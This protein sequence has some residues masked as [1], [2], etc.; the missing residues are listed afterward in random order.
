M[1]RAPRST[2]ASLGHSFH[3]H[4]KLHPVVARAT[5]MRTLSTKVSPSTG[6][7]YDFRRVTAPDWQINSQARN[8]NAMRHIVRHEHQPHRLSHPQSDLSR[9]KSETSCMDN[10]HRHLRHSISRTQQDHPCEYHR[11]VSN[12]LGRSC[13]GQAPHCS[14]FPR[15]GG[16]S[17]AAV[18]FNKDFLQLARRRMQPAPAASSLHSRPRRGELTRSQKPGRAPV[19]PR[20]PHGEREI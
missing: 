1:T 15:H 9:N 8:G 3:M 6:S 14:L 4:H 12:K 5:I 16:Q 18:S 13:E 19:P 2:L 20:V 7:N 11:D 10:N 17:A